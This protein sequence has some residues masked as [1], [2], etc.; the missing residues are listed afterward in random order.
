MSV[1]D[2]NSAVR[3]HGYFFFMISIYI[4]SSLMSRMTPQHILDNSVCVIFRPAF[5]NASFLLNC[6]LVR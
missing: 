6:G 3:Y 2:L 4:L 1:K 5:F